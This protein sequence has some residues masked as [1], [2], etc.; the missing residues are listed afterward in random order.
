MAGLW[1]ERGN[2]CQVSHTYSVT[3]MKPIKQLAVIRAQQLGLTWALAAAQSESWHWQRQES[4]TK[5]WGMSSCRYSS[6]CVSFSW[7]C[8]RFTKWCIIQLLQTKC[9]SVSILLLLSFFFFAQKVIQSNIC[10]IHI[11]T[12]YISTNKPTR[13]TCHWLPFKTSTVKYKE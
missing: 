7:W 10:I 1:N 3:G 11:S 8:R 9:V 13:E 4:V 2:K 12:S 6:C 5:I